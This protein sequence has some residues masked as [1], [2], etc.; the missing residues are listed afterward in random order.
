MRCRTRLSLPPPASLLAKST[1][2]PRGSAIA[3]D[4]REERR[5]R[6]PIVIRPRELGAKGKRR[7]RERER[8]IVGGEERRK[9]DNE[10]GTRER[11][12]REGGKEEERDR[13][14]YGCV[15]TPRGASQRALRRPTT[16]LTPQWPDPTSVDAL[17][18]PPRPLER[19]GMLARL[20]GWMDR[21]VDGRMHRL[22]ETRER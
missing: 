19:K 14:G 15:A 10:G 22:E 13:C 7:E 16:H 20:D 6:I 3:R 4:A 21:W 5:G 1:S 11:G 8:E 2:G 17:F 12:E 9:R 18:F